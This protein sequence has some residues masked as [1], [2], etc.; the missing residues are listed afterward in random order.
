V[1]QLAAVLKHNNELAERARLSHEEAMRSAVERNHARTQ[2]A[3]AAFQEA[4]R[5]W[6]QVRGP[7]A[8]KPIQLATERLRKPMPSM[9]ACATHIHDVM[10]PRLLGSAEIRLHYAGL[11]RCL[12]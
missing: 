9:A 1:V 4:K 2:R 8:A 12:G 5:Q 6:H 7:A 11:S 3:Q 10:V